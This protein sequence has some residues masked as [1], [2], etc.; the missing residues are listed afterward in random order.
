MY[1]CWNSAISSCL[2]IGI[3]SKKSQR[4][5]PLSPVEALWTQQ[6]M[7]HR[8]FSSSESSD[9]L[10]PLGVCWVWESSGCCGD[11]APFRLHRTAMVPLKS[12]T[13]SHNCPAHKRSYEP[14]N[15]AWRTINN[16]L[17]IMFCFFLHYT[18]SSFQLLHLLGICFLQQCYPEC[19]RA[20]ASWKAESF[21]DTGQSVI[22]LYLYPVPILPELKPELTAVKTV[23][24]QRLFWWKYLITHTYNKCNSNLCTLL[25]M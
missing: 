1:S 23:T 14:F 18:K 10:V 17:I 7:A 11:S 16:S 6:L 2:E 19:P 4:L 3:V 20:L 12:T 15:L 24:P 21:I 13:A 8:S 5:L 22:H 9:N 25:N